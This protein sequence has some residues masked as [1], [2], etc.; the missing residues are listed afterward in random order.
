ML[1]GIIITVL[2]G[3]LV[4]WVASIVMNRDSQQGAIGNIVVG[5]VGAFLGGLLSRLVGVNSGTDFWITLNW[6]D[7]FWALVGAIVL[8]AILNYAQTRRIR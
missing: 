3:A 1:V 8:C 2:L 7:V 5:I 4:G 6:A